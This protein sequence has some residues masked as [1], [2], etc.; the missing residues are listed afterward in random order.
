MY[1]KCIYLK[2]MIIT[3][4]KQ[5]RK[6]NTM[7][8]RYIFAFLLTLSLMWIITPQLI[9]LALKIDFV[10]KPKLNDRKIHKESKPYLASIGMFFTFWITILIFIRDFDIKIISMFISSFLIFGIGII[11][12]SYKI[13]GKDLK[14]LPKMTVQVFACVIIY[15]ANIRF[16]GFIEPFNNS[17]IF[18]PNWLQFILTVTWLFGVTTVINFSDGLDGLAG[19]ISC[20]SSGTLFLVAL[21]KG[22][23]ISALMSI[24]LVGICLGYLKFNKYPSKILMGDSGATFLGFMLA[25]ISLEGAFKQATI[26]SIFI[27]IL[28]LGV[29]IFDNIFV[30]FKRIREGRPI[31]VGDTSQIHFRLIAEGLNQKQT[32]RFL[33][34]LSVCS[35]LF[36]IIIVLLQV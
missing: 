4:L 18:L 2:H 35:S 27:P 30:V 22:S 11:D 32:V 26:I 9:K 12:D 20:I 34:L 5:K 24:M 13:K 29:P 36:A 28:A 16:V 3:L 1:K 14:A 15:I 21:A 17:Y 10:E 33:Y 25:V 23:E 31:Y 19:G 8:T 6:G 7:N